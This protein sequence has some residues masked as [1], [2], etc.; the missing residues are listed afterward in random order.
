[1]YKSKPSDFQMALEEALLAEDGILDSHLGTDQIINVEAPP[2]G[3][4]EAT[5]SYFDQQFY[6]QDQVGMSVASSI[7]HYR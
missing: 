4:V 3:F 1:M 7:L 6:S 5:E 2:S